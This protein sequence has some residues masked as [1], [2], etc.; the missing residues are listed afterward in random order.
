MSNWTIP[1]ILGSV[2]D[3]PH[4]DVIV[5][6]FNRF[7]R[8]YK[9]NITVNVRACSA[10]KNSSYLRKIISAYENYVPCFITIAGKSNALSAVVDAM[11]SKPV[12]SCPPISTRSNN[13]HD[14]F[15]SLSLPSGVA[16]MTVLNYENCC[17]AVVKIVGLLDSNVNRGMIEY[18]SSLRNKIRIEDLKTVALYSKENLDHSDRKDESELYRELKLVRKGKV[19]DIYTDDSGRD[20][21]VMRATNR[22]SSFDRFICDVPYK[23]EMLNR[24]S[25]WWF[26]QTQDI[27]PNHF[28]Q[29]HGRDGMVVHKC[30]PIMVE[31]VVRSYMTGSTKTSI[32]KNYESGMR[33]YCGHKLRDGYKRNEPLDETIVTPTTKGETDELIDAKGIVESGLMTQ[34]DWEYC[35]R[36][37][38]KLFEFGQ[39]V[40]EH[41]GMI[42][43]DTKYE[44]GKAPDGSIML[45][46]EVH[47]PDSSRYWVR[48]SYL[49]RMSSGE[50]PENVDKDIIRKWAKKTYED[51][52]SM[53]GGSFDVPDE[54]V[55]LV[56]LRYIQL[57]K[58]IT[59]KAL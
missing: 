58:I 22:L 8:I 37:A 39:K 12:L 14:L 32:W 34:K 42:L 4:S 31:F 3:K 55:D 44:F 10:H 28:I 17:L 16:P 5:S 18:Q 46:D 52:Y 24:I 47:T 49:E 51:P 36:T 15:S 23:G 1:V 21:L 40:A 19:R 45:I 11:T 33:E 43:V 29:Y 53:E 41:F 57:Y 20:I 27:V 26:N 6:F 59:D 54:L 2:K 48:H 50:E 38:L 9:T 25:I 35:E 7:N 13:I 30:E 56:S